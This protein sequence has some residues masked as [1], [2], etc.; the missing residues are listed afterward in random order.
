[1]SDNAILQALF[2][3]Q[4]LQILELGTVHDKFSDDYLFA[5]EIGV[6]PYFQDTDGT[7]F[8]APHEV[9][10][11]NFVVSPEQVKDVFYY[12][13][14]RWNAQE[15]PTFYQLE[16]YYGGKFGGVYGR[17]SLIFICRYAYLHGCFDKTFW[18]TLLK[19]G[20]HPSE[21]SSITSPYDR[22]DILF[23]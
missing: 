21:A 13:C 23:N 19:S 9:Y 12:L 4:R 2:N 14:E 11:S 6:Y 16:K 20:Q 18:N 10:K 1:M 22:D 17:P 8:Q 7:V 5:W 3:Q 15:T